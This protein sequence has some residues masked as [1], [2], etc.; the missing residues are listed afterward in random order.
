[1]DLNGQFTRRRQYQG[2]RLIGT[3]PW[4]RWMLEQMLK[5]RHEKCRRLART[6]LRLTGDI[7]ALQRHGE[8]LRL[9]RRTEIKPGIRQSAEGRIG[10][11]QL[12]K[13]KSR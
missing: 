13:P 3:P 1:M 5:Q 12:G 6:G 11:A 10:Q 7:L 9:Y 2:P 8:G 4:F